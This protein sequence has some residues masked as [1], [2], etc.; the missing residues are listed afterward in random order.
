MEFYISVGLIAVAALLSSFIGLPMLKIIQ[1]SG[2]KARGVVAWWKGSA[3]DVIVRY[4]ALMVFGF[5]SMIVFV[6]CFITFEYVGYCAV[7]LYDILAVVFIVSAGKSGSN[8]VKYTGRIIRMLIVNTLIMLVLGAGVCWA[9]Y[10]SEYCQ[11]VTVALAMLAPFT[12]LAA[13]A[14]TYPFEKLNNKKY[15]KRAKAKLTQ[16]SPIVIGITGS[17]GKTTAKNLLCGMLS[18]KYTVLATPGSYN[19]PM[20]VCKTINNDLGD[21]QYFIAEMGARYKGDIKELCEIVSPAMGIITAVGDM[22]IETMGSRANV[23]N[24]KFELGA[25]LPQGGLLVLN[26]YNNDCAELATRETNCDKLAVGAE[27]ADIAYENLKINGDGTN[28]DLVINGERYSVTSKLL[29]AHIAELTCVCAGIALKCGVNAEQIVAAVQAAPAVAHR[30]QIVP[31]ADP[32]VTVIDDAYNS[33][34]VGAKNALDVLNCCEGKK[35]IITPGFVELGAIEKECNIML[36][37]QIAEV[38]DYA[39]FIGSR[40]KELKKGAL[41]AEMSEGAITVCGSRDE[42]VAALK[43]IT[44]T[45]AVLFENDLPDNIK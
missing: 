5:I 17:Y 44:G 20:G 31:S 23:A 36:G 8:G 19:T 42:A 25:A 35:I 9:V 18:S 29:G 2:Y 21:E 14:I 15:I 10:Y 16:K 39:F 11:T 12:T 37:R 34:P 41:A 45:K 40:A 6:G 7:A 28:F 32:S 27:N 22:H 24:V 26:G 43:D 1:L 13:N 4:A 30:L 33:N 38:C 3:Y